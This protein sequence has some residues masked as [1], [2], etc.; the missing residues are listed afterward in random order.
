MIP[1]VEVVEFIMGF[2]PSLVGNPFLDDL[3]HFL[4]NMCTNAPFYCYPLIFQK[5]INLIIN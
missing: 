2:L 3:G 4:P 5:T 1:K